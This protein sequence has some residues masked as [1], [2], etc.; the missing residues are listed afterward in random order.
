[1]YNILLV[2]DDKR[3]LEGI[4]KNINWIDYGMEICAVACNGQQGLSLAKEKNPDII[5]SDI[6]MPVMNGLD[7]VKDY[8]K[9]K[10]DVMVIFMTCFDEF[11]FAKSA[12]DLNANA[13][14]LKPISLDELSECLKKLADI[15]LKELNEKIYKKNLEQTIEASKPLLLDEFYR[16][17]LFGTIKSDEEFREKLDF[18]AVPGEI[19]Y[20]SCMHIEIDNY[21]VI[22]GE[23]GVREKYLLIEKVLY[24]VRE[25][26][27]KTTGCAVVKIDDKSLAVI[28]FYYGDKQVDYLVNNMS[29]ANYVRENIR[30]LANVK[31]TISVSE[32]VDNIKML[33]EQYTLARKT[34][35]SKFYT[36]G[37]CVLLVKDCV[38][39]DGIFQYDYNEIKNSIL[40]YINGKD[41]KAFPVLLEKYYLK[42]AGYSK[43]HLKA[44]SY[45][46][47]NVLQ[48]YLLENNLSLQQVF[49][50]ELLV[51]DKLSRY[52]TI[53]DIRKWIEN[54]VEAVTQCVGSR[55]QSRAAVIVSDI[56]T[57]IDKN[58]AS[59]GNT[60]EVAEY[61]QISASYANSVFKAQKGVTIFEFL[62][63]R[64]MNAACKMLMNPYCRINEI[65]A[66]LGYISPAYFTSVFKL[67]YNM[68]PKEYRKKF[69]SSSIS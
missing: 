38:E 16:N 5:I 59:I 63:E 10:P 15:K 21:S 35:E 13:Y 28:I 62:V 49:G 37:N 9:I 40:D 45:T 11:D 33:A 32:V 8:K 29:L 19:T 51:W 65:A 43:N 44:L 39:N 22:Y 31:V 24:S 23:Y 1:M 66:E 6:S 54:I 47:V 17:L 58:Y 50:E 52:E 30:L 12:I 14:I 25:L 41:N 18:L 60:T 53:L 7:M 56:E 3:D 36:S 27:A 69:S 64:K 4:S 68:T 42:G 67:H 57:Y 48:N 34:A 2:D 20:F 55:N 46:I 26:L 61:L